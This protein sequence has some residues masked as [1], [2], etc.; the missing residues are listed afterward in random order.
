MGDHDGLE[1]RVVATSI[2]LRT[3]NVHYSGHVLVTQV[4]GW[5]SVGDLR[6][7]VAALVGAPIYNIQLFV[8]STGLG[9]FKKIECKHLS[10][11]EGTLDNE[12]YKDVT[13]LIAISC[14]TSVPHLYAT[15]LVADNSR[16]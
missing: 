6:G 2:M 15:P 11:D 3:Y 10:S 4:N 8:C 9:R 13:E 14:D 12:Q 5:Q 16:P 7:H 1:E